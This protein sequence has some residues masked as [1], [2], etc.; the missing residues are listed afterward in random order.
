EHNI[1]VFRKN[2]VNGYF[3]DAGRG[4]FGKENDHLTAVKKIDAAGGLSVLNH[5]GDWNGANRDKN[6]ALSD[7][8]RELFASI[9][10]AYPSCLGIEIV[11]SKDRCTRHDR[12]LWDRLL[13]RLIPLGRNVWGFSN[14][15]SHT[16][17]DAG[18]SYELFV[19]RE[20]TLR[21]IK[22]AMIS[23]S[24]FACSRYARYELGEDFVGDGWFGKFGMSVGESMIRLDVPDGCSVRWISCGKTV[25]E[26]GVFDLAE[27]PEAEIYVR[28]ELSGAAGMLYSQAFPISGAEKFAEPIS[29][30]FEPRTIAERL[31]AAKEH[32]HFAEAARFL[33]RELKKHHG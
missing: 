23:G 26:G 10:Y 9:L 22:R 13:E 2:H 32:S 4:D 12:L 18:D 17:S 11:N 33:G 28:F 24:F 3:C 5:L 19:L 30:P 15:D 27:H 6:I 29:P 7:T 14:D 8:Q 31:A 20:N 1:A 16:D 25:C 21:E